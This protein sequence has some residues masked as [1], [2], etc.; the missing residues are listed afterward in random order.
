MKKH[1]ENI[2][3]FGLNPIVAINKFN[4]DTEKEIQVL[5]DELNG[6]C[7]FSL[8]ESW[9]KG[10]DGALDLASKVIKVCEMPHTFKNTYSLDD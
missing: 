6:V 5:E 2:K 3:S 10:S 8:L 9:E 1:I 4:A 7:E